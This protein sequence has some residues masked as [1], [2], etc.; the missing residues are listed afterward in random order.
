METKIK[1]KLRVLLWSRGPA[2]LFGYEYVVDII[3]T[4]VFSFVS[5]VILIL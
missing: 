1:W 3:L 4:Y 2:I 5:T